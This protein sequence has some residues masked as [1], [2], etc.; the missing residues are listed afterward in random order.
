[1]EKELLER[2]SSFEMTE[3]AGLVFQVEAFL[4][5]NF[6]F[7]R[8]L[9]MG[10]TEVRN[11]GSDQ[12]LPLTV[13]TL[14][15]IVRKA[16]KIG[17]GENKSPKQD[18][19][20]YVNSDAVTD[21][22]PIAEWLGG[23]PEWDGEN[24]VAA[25]FSRIPGVTSEQ[26]AF[27]STWFRSAVAHWLHMDN[28]HG[29]ECVPV[30]IGEQGCGKSTFAVRLLPEELRCYFLD[31]INFT[32]KFDADMALTHN[33]LVNID[34][35]A[36]MGLSQQGRLKQTLS[37]VKVNGRP[38]F[39]RSQEDRR[40]YASFIATTNDEHPLCDQTGSRRYLCI[41]IPKGKLIDN[42]TP[43]DYEQLYAQ[44]HYELTVGKTPY[45]FNTD[46]TRRIQQLN[47]PFFL[48]DDMETMISNCFRLP[49]K[50]EEGQWVNSKTILE[51]L[52]TRYPSLQVSNST[53]VKIGQTLK[54][55]GCTAK[56]FSQ[57]QKYH[58]VPLKAA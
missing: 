3:T 49:L 8:N 41:S 52:R 47:L 48:T 56:R 39:G 44:L 4:E 2:E 14:N 35:F 53:K 7:R 17:I 27:L 55:M 36:N 11:N 29:N 21:F 38:I 9:L 30:L 32:N 57:G 15:S 24:H 45:W 54:C 33:L 12:W 25:L 26:L 34:E 20:E 10:K 43:I 37:K 1:M 40:R 16:K 13:E 23:L 28:V 5:E 19:E 6:Q 18:I 58:L 22:D 51:A 50:D 46:E 31:H 42:S